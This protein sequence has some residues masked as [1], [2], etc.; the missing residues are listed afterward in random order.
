M[1]QLFIRYV[2]P[3]IRMADLV[4]LAEAAQ[5][6]TMGEEDRAGAV[7]ADQ[8]RFLTEMR[9]V[10]ADLRAASG[11]ADTSLAG[12]TINAALPGAQH[13][14]RQ[15]GVSFVNSLAKPAGCSG[16]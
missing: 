7:L 6:T 5:E 13:T 12:K 1:R 4:V 3:R 11:I 16:P 10:A 9:C 8:R 15:G 2:I 14:V